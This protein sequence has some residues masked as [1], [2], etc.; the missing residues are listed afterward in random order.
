MEAILAA[1]IG[2]ALLAAFVAAGAML[3]MRW[4][5]IDVLSAAVVSTAI[6]LGLGALYFGIG[7]YLGIG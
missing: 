1:V 3:L 2:F 5:E 4:L 7:L 6:V